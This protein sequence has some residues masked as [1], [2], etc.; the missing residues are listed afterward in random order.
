MMVQNLA[1]P[2]FFKY[3]Y[4]YSYRRS[5]LE[6]EPPLFSGSGFITLSMGKIFVYGR[7]SVNDQH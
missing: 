5:E 2:I 7:L 6:P 3:Y 4:R 1:L